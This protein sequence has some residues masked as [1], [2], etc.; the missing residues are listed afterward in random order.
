MSLRGIPIA[1]ELH[2]SYLVV[3][4][5]VDRGQQSRGL[6][7]MV[8]NQ[9][10]MLLHLSHE[11]YEEIHRINHLHDNFNMSGGLPSVQR[12]FY[13]ENRLTMGNTNCTC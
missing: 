2:M 13:G 10:C 4:Q 11:T 12:N 1:L 3:C 7:P 5:K 9:V 6:K 8:H